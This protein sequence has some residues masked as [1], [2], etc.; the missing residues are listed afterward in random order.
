MSINGQPV[1]TLDNFRANI[2]TALQETDHHGYCVANR[3][4]GELST[5]V[6]GPPGD[7]CPPAAGGEHLCFAAAATAYCLPARGLIQSTNPTCRAATVCPHPD[8]SCLVPTFV[9]KSAANSSS[10]KLVHI[11]R[12]SSFAAAAAKKDFLF[13]GNPALIY[14]SVILSDYCPRYAWLS[15]WLPDSLLK[16]ARYIASFSGA[17]AVLNVVPCYMLDGQHMMEVLME[18]ALKGA[19]AARRRRLQ[20]TVTLLGKRRWSAY[21]GGGGRGISWG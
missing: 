18:M 8:H 14:T 7:C 4:I 1:R 20:T 17:L 2:L 21:G 10:T 6:T 13:V 12:G 19:W 16:M 11:G 15:G 3:T 9:A 5:T